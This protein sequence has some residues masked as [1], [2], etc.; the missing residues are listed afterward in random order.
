MWVEL[1]HFCVIL[2]C[3]LTIFCGVTG[4]VGGIRQV[5]SLLAPVRMATMLVAILLTASFIALAYA[6]VTDDFSVRY[7]ASHSNSLLPV[8]YKVAAVW[9]GHE[10]SLLL[11]VMMLAFWA[12]AVSLLSHELPERL[13]MLVLAV[14]A[15]LGSGF[16]LFILLTSNPFERLN[17]VPVDGADLNPLL[18]DIGLVAHPPFLYLGY[19]GFSVAFAFAIAALITGQLDAAWAKFSRP[20]TVAAWVFLTIG[21][22]L[23]SMWAYYELGWGGWWFWDPVENASFMPW[24]A[25]T[26]LIHSLAV[27]EKRGVFKHWTVLLAI[28]AFSLSLLGT[29]LVRSGVLTSVHAFATDPARGSFIL[30]FLAI[31]VG[32]ALALYAWR[33]PALSNNVRF[34]WLSREASLLLNN[35]FLVAACAAVFIGTLF[36]LLMDAIGG[37]KFS[38]GPPYYNRV[39]TPLWLALLFF[40]SVAPHLHWRQNKWARIA[41]RT[42]LCWG[43]ALLLGALMPLAFGAWRWGVALALALAWSVVIAS[44][45]DIVQRLRKTGKGMSLWRSLRRQPRAFLGMHLAH[46][47]LAVFAM[48]ATVVTAYETEYDAVIMPKETITMGEHQVHFQN[49]QGFVG[50]NYEALIGHFRIADEDG[51]VLGVLKPEKR[52]YVSGGEPMTEAAIMRQFLG[53]LY[54][55]LGEMQGSDRATSGWLIRFYH[56]PLMGWVWAGCLL[57][58]LGGWLAMTDPRYRRRNTK[59]ATA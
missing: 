38:V 25:G 44:G 10:G 24:I 3:V 23:G 39:L 42:Y 7:V 31:V 16:L 35:V 47:G 49:L 59:E 27:A 57:M 52:Q 8:F 1:G 50:P 19:V 11:W 56:K 18:Q 9:G 41:G 28:A 55:S 14:L 12:A 2:A 48:G 40:L 29:F 4:L 37:G 20:W 22:L 21:I 46:I 17:P 36:P 51:R 53:D 54:I 33:A 58:V 5:H 6:F 30:A 15:L 45:E 13:Q 34:T 43:A 26:A 32:S